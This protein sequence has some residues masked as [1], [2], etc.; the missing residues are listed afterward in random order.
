MNAP[1][2]APGDYVDAPR[3]LLA[4]EL[5]E[6][7]AVLTDAHHGIGDPPPTPD[8]VRAAA[9]DALACGRA[10]AEKAIRHEWIAQS[11]ALR[12]GAPL[13]DVAIASGL[14][15]DEVLAGLRSR[16]AGQVEHDCMTR[17]A[18]DELLALID[19]AAASG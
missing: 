8:R 2:P 16:I 19:R 7:E 10:L 14:D 9:L 6:H 13:A 5:D 4:A 12:Y 11:E 15:V 17:A 18:A 3:S 1:P